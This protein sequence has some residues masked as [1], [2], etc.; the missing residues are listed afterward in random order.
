MRK[1]LYAG[2]GLLMCAV[3]ASASD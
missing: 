3:H 2:V 1:G